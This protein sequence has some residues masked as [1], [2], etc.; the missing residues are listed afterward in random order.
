MSPKP[1]SLNFFSFLFILKE[2][3]VIL[4]SLITLNITNYAEDFIWI[5]SHSYPLSSNLCP[6]PYVVAQAL[7]D[8]TESAEI[9]ALNTPLSLDPLTTTASILNGNSILWPAAHAKKKI[10]SHP[11]L[12]LSH[13]A[14]DPSIILINTTFKRYPESN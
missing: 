4:S 1:R 13:L 11:F 2:F 8:F 6:S 14:C 12:S 10:W 5:C 7:Y 3:L 9:R